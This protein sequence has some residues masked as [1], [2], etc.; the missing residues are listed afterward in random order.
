MDRLV[1][2]CIDFKLGDPFGQ[3]PPEFDRRA[4]SE[5]VCVGEEGEPLEQIVQTFRTHVLRHSLNFGA[6]TF[7][8]H[9]D[10]GNAIAGVLGDIADAFLQQNLASAEYS[11]V[12]TRVELEM[13]KLLRKVIGYKVEHDDDS[14]L[15]GGGAFVFGGSGAN[16]S[17]LL[18]AREKLRERLVAQGK[19]YRARKTRILA[20][21][22]FSHYSMRRSLY[23]LGLGNGDLPANVRREEGLDEECLFQVSTAH[24]RMDPDDL[25]RAVARVLERDEDIMC[26]FA[27]S[28]DS[29]MMAFDDLEAIA[30]LAERHGIWVHVDACEGG[31]VLFSPRR[32]H[33]MQG[34]EAANSISLDPHKTLMVPYNLSAFLFRDA[35]DLTRVTGGPAEVIRQG[36]L[37]MG[38]YTPA[39]GSKSFISLKLWFLLKHWGWRN[40][41]DEIDRRHALALEAA[42]WIREHPDL[43]L[44]N[45]R[46][47]HNAVA[48]LFVPRG[49]HEPTVQSVNRLNRA[50]HVRLNE[51]SRYFVHSFPSVDDEAI[52]GTRDAVVWPLRM[53]FGNPLTTPEI[54]RKCLDHVVEIGSR[55]V[56]EG[57]NV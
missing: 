28:G 13:L 20:N 11:P 43:R 29:R 21:R 14:C 51:G 34:I 46:V 24:F 35:M 47:E 53:M 45:P 49:W 7:L 57:V 23:L 40:L 36:D 16:F 39:V 6:P 10:C 26:V 19:T 42:A 55:L 18:A 50:L 27:V 1:D 38:T 25:E 17:C 12:A 52:I 37:S 54:V 3:V 31:Q 8:A 33:L 22:P 30:R 41:A 56:E 9:P 44:V 5:A 48:F 15:A 32:R 4:L 2:A